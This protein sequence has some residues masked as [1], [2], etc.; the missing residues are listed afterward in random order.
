[1]I[2]NRL[3]A[4]TVE[5]KKTPGYFSDGGSLYLRI[6]P[7]LTKSWAFIYRKADKRTEIG[8]GSTSDVTLEQARDKAD[9]LRKQLKS[10]IAPLI[11]RQRQDSENK[12]QRA[13]I[14]NVVVAS[15]VKFHSG[16][17]SK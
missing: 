11:E 5:T 9:T 2:K 10:G 13:V 14:V 4:R 6:T 7:N 3:T 1:M 8:L 15:T 17:Y 12:A 16:L